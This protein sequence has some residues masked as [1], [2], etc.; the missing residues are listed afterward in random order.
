MCKPNSFWTGS[1]ASPRLGKGNL[2]FRGNGS[3]NSN[4]PETEEKTG[5]SF[6]F[7][8][9]SA[10]VSSSSSASAER[11]FSLWPGFASRSRPQLPLTS[12]APVKLLSDCFGT[13]KRIINDFPATTIKNRRGKP[14]GSLWTQFKTGL[15]CTLVC[16]RVFF[17][18]QKPNKNWIKIKIQIK[19]EK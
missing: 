2:I 6:L 14:K 9:L 18:H 10:F 17:E 5:N 19:I 16:V 15:A 7:L 8:L 4:R 1:K 11:K 12:T 3:L 13:E